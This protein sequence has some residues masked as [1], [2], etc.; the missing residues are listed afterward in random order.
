MILRAQSQVIDVRVDLAVK[1]DNHG[2]AR[3]QYT[4]IGLKTM[5]IKGSISPCLP[6]P[7]AF[8]VHFFLDQHYYEAKDLN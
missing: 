4:W 6:S 8:F 1:I 5:L 7:Q 2:Y 3:S